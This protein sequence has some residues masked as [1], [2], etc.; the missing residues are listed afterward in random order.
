MAANACNIYRT[1]ITCHW[2]KFP[3][4]LGLFDLWRQ[5][6]SDSRLP[7]LRELLDGDCF[8]NVMLERPILNYRI[9]RERAF[10]AVYCGEKLHKLTYFL[11]EINRGV[12]KTTKKGIYRL[13]QDFSV[14]K[15]L[16]VTIWYVSQPG[17]DNPLSLMLLLE[18]LLMLNSN[19]KL[20][21]IL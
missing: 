20:F 21:T 2:L 17:K 10:I 12:Y 13:T 1:V 16:L 4:R 6:V 9:Y 5:I 8:F 7:A 14:W 15:S 3:Y 19:E 18:T 11:I